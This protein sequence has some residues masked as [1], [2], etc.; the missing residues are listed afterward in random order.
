[1]HILEGTWRG[2]DSSKADLRQK[3]V[4]NSK[5]GRKRASLLQDWVHFTNT[6]TGQENEWPRHR[7]TR[8][9]EVGA[10]QR[11]LARTTPRAFGG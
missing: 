8:G 9:V 10:S 3:G 7:P 4:H 11:R 2:R 1:M 6:N 5:L